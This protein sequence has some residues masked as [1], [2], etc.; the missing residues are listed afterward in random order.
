MN[1]YHNQ[2]TIAYFHSEFNRLESIDF[3]AA[4]GC[5]GCIAHEES[6]QLRGYDAS[7]MVAI[8]DADVIEFEHDLDT[9][10]FDSNGNVVPGTERA[11]YLVR[12]V[13]YFDFPWEGEGY[14]PCHDYFYEVSRVGA[15]EYAR[16]FDHGLGVFRT[17]DV[18]V[19]FFDIDTG[20]ELSFHAF[21][22]DYDM[23]HVAPA[24]NIDMTDLPF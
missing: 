23:P 16:D 18:G 13:M 20:V 24:A 22:A 7:E 1:A 2:H 9:V 8:D 6:D 5:D 11:S 12:T 19:E 21:L 14:E 3:D 17:D 10:E 4:M 15:E